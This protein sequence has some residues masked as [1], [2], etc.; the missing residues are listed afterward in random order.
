[1]VFPQTSIDQTS[2][3]SQVLRFVRVKSAGTPE[4]WQ[5]SPEKQ[6]ARFQPASI[7]LVLPWLPCPSTQHWGELHTE[8]AGLVVNGEG[9][10][11]LRSCL[12][13]KLPSGHT[14]HKPETEPS[15]QQQPPRR[16]S[17]SHKNSSSL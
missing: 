4:L 11:L 6:G 1:M 13:E 12:L 2:N 16:P 3:K 8:L 5:R 14:A 15:G 17:H 7:M 10:C 9:G